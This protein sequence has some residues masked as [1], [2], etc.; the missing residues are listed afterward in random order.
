MFRRSAILLFSVLLIA[1]ELWGGCVVC[2]QF[3]QGP[4][5][6]NSCCD[7]TGHC[8]KTSS[9]A[10]QKPCHN[11]ASQKPCQLQQVMV[12]K[13]NPTVLQLTIAA[14]P[15][16]RT[17][18]DLLLPSVTLASNAPQGPFSVPRHDRQAVLSTFLI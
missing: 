11:P 7:P 17:P 15:G 8:K 16:L 1:T 14:H 4:L 3:F 12:P 13:K 18:S 5:A 9:P 2:P 10:S 6:A